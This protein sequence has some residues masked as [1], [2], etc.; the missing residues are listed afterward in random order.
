[1]R[2]LQRDIA[3]A[4]SEQRIAV[5]LAPENV[6]YA[7]K[8]ADILQE[9]GCELEADMLIRV[10]R[11][12]FDRA[13]FDEKNRLRDRLI[14]LVERCE[15]TPRIGR[16]KNV[17][18]ARELFDIHIVD[19]V[20][21]WITIVDQNDSV[22]DVA[23]IEGI[24]RFEIIDL[25]H[26]I[27]KRLARGVPWELPIAALLA[28]LARRCEPDTAIFDVGA[29]IGTHTVTL[30]REHTDT[31]VA[32]EP[33]EASRKHLVANLQRNR[34]ANVQVRPVACG[35]KPGTGRMTRVTDDNPG[36]AQLAV[37]EGDVVVSTIDAER[38]RV[39]E[40]VAVIKIDVEG[41][42]R[43][44][45]R[46]AQRTLAED[47]PVVVCEFGALTDPPGMRSRAVR[48]FLSTFGYEGER[49]FR[50]DWVCWPSAWS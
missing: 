6:K 28:E 2:L 34:C 18:T 40:R 45:L 50:S 35:D 48:A 31:V 13:Q 38:D 43:A 14:G 16:L 11:D 20:A 27:H 33:V 44:V 7:R 30:A 25:A 37:G 22:G 15:K 32:F 47:Q 24:G 46:G 1:V 12:K 23:N 9:A 49:F 5:R 26:V 39:G 10:A 8:L 19:S 21:G 41:H 4:I 42:E 3:G 17:D 36:M 29:Y